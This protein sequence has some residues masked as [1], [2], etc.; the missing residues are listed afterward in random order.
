MRKALAISQTS[1][2]FAALKKEALRMKNL[3]K[4]KAPTYFILPEND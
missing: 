2:T 1:R 4:I 3:S